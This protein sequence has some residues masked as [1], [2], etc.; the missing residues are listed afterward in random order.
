ML[1]YST[2][3]F[4]KVKACNFR[5]E[6]RKRRQSWSAIN[7]RTSIV[8]YKLEEWI[9]TLDN[10]ENSCTKSI[11]PL[12]KLESK[13]KSPTASPRPNRKETDITTSYSV[14]KIGKC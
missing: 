12:K 3:I 6:E 14:P 1:N 11:D 2:I 4:S 10:R 13:T 8:K 5:H 9:F 7:R